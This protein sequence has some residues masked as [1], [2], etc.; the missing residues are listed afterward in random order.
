M[1][2]A[3]SVLLLPE[4]LL[5]AVVAFITYL[6]GILAQELSKGF[7]RAMGISATALA[8][9]VGG[10]ANAVGRAAR[11]LSVP[12]SSGQQIRSAVKDAVSDRYAERG[13]PVRA[14]L[15]FP[16]DLLEDQL[17]SLS[18]QLWH[19]APDQY[20]ETDRLAAESAFRT[21]VSL[22]LLVLGIELGILG[23]WWVALLFLAAALVLLRQARVL[24]GERRALLATALSQRLA[25]SQLLAG[26]VRTLEE[27]N[28]L[29][30]TGSLEW[31]V[32]TAIA[33]EKAGNVD[34]YDRMID[35]A[36]REVSELVNFSDA[37]WEGQA[38]AYADGATT[39]LLD[40]R[41]PKGADL[42]SRKTDEAISRV[43][44]ATQAPQPVDSIDD[45]L[46]AEA[47]LK[48]VGREAWRRI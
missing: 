33:M 34:G 29:Q 46:S 14:S 7:R 21:G 40:H 8:G 42:I 2:I 12:D 11:T 16:V 39:L 27:L 28:L 6:I 25:E 43:K 31:Q 22:P 32:A 24:E 48:R 5:F 36:V 38:R 20:H 23:P 1:E 18:M 26:T 45:G 44:E 3:H 37:D 10:W 17:E 19:K 47:V 30:S 35:D 15:C 13:L 41:D 4:T 9:K